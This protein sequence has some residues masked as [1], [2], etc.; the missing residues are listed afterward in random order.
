M[1]G[2]RQPA[3]RERVSDVGLGRCT[4]ALSTPTSQTWLLLVFGCALAAGCSPAHPPEPAP[5]RSPLPEGG[6]PGFA[7]A[8]A[9]MPA[10]SEP[11]PAGGFGSLEEAEAALHRAE[12]ELAAAASESS[13]QD[14]TEEQAAPAG[15]APAPKAGAAQQRSV[16]VGTC[17]RVC[18]AF[19][20]LSRAADAVCR[21]AGATSDRCW[22]AR[23][24]VDQNRQRV[25]GCGCGSGR[26]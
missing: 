23:R 21:I 24:R 4:V 16:S 22:Q 26:P 11:E 17:D 9:T 13:P 6:R 15:A 8:P 1:A 25:S 14:T 18:R 5:V 3:R 7:P 19:D 12:R 20:S 2:E 10:A